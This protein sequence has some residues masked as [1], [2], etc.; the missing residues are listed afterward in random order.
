MNAEIFFVFLKILLTVFLVLLLFAFSIY[1]MILWVYEEAFYGYSKN[2][3]KKIIKNQNFFQRIS[4]MYLF[5]LT[6]NQKGKRRI[7][8]YWLYLLLVMFLCVAAILYICG[9][10]DNK[11]AL[12]LFYFLNLIDLLLWVVEKMNKK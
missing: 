4:L 7:I 10:T 3:K 8:L 6:N 12:Y 5:K 11:T 2:H 1:L 9:V